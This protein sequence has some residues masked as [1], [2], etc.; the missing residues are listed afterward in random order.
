MQ[1]NSPYKIQRLQPRKVE[2]QNLHFRSVSE[3]KIA[4]TLDRFGVLFFPNCLIFHNRD[5]KAIAFSS[6]RFTQSLWR[7]GNT[8]E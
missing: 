5:E 3:V 7:S 8:I 6:D 4:Q 1:T 2:W